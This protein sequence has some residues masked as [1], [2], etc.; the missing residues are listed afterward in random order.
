MLG[1]WDIVE[2]K[3]ESIL[4]ELQVYKNISD[5]DNESFSSTAEVY[6]MLFLESSQ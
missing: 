6:G 4:M 5:H 2:A 1:N 3:T